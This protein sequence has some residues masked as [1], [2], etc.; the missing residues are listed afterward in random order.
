MAVNQ[1]QMF[2]DLVSQLSSGE[3]A[4]IDLSRSLS[5]ETPLFDPSDTGMKY[6]IL[7]TLE[8]DGCETGYLSLPEHFGTHV[9]A[10]SHF[11]KGLSIDNVPPQK[12]ILPGVIID[13]R[14]QVQANADYQLT[15]AAVKNAEEVGPI[16]EGSI[17]L[18][19]TG[20]SEK[21]ADASSYRNPDSSGKMHFP[22][23]SVEAAKYLIENKK[24]S[25][26]GIDT[27]SID[28]GASPDYAV[29]KYALSQGVL[30]VENL[31]ELEKLPL[32]GSVIFCGALKIQN[33]TGSP[34]RVLAMAP[35]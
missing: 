16:P 29:H 6:E 15:V 20:W 14:K 21:Y 22:G 18:L 23:F 35:N 19:L 8:N 25:A 9:D 13:I 3:I 17:I 34:A 4:I 12:L 1:N 31:H 5:T 33:G 7:S 30:L 27:L 26:F 24:P 32:R 10:P 2:A 28:H 11:V